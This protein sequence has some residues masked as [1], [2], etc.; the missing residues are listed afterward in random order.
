MSNDYRR[1]LN[2]RDPVLYIDSDPMPEYSV[3][4]L[5]LLGQ[6]GYTY[7]GAA[8]GRYT[9]NMSR[10]VPAPARRIDPFGRPTQTVAGPAP[11][12]DSSDIARS[13]HRQQQQRQQ[14]EQD[15]QRMI[16]Q[17]EQ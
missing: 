12:L 8:T 16:D 6:P 9:R 11:P 14:A 2:Q 10:R 15:Q 1:E 13:Q 7:I 3:E 17:A 5:P 4:E